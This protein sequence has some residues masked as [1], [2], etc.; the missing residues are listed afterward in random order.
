MPSTY[1]NQLIR[2]R[3][4][5]K[6]C[7]LPQQTKGVSRQNNCQSHI[8][9]SHH[10]KHHRGHWQP[11]QVPEERLGRGEEGVNNSGVVPLLEVEA[12]LLQN[13]NGPNTVVGEGVA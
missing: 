4:R 13:V 9:P 1:E 6:P 5:E 10:Q 12:G 3:E 8:K 2:K 11:C 7:T